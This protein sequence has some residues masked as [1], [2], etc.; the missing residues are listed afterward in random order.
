[1]AATNDGS[2][3]DTINGASFSVQSRAADIVIMTLKREV[4][5]YI[6]REERYAPKTQEGR[7]KLLRSFK[8]SIE[9]DSS[10][11]LTH[12]G[13]GVVKLIDEKYDG[14][15]LTNELN[16]EE[17]INKWLL[18]GLIKEL[19]PKLKEK[20]RGLELPIKIK[21]AV[22]DISS[23]RPYTG[24]QPQPFNILKSDNL[25]DTMVPIHNFYTINSVCDMTVTYE[26]FNRS[27]SHIV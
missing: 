14:V 24:R 8:L 20:Y 10:P 25:D 19:V 26:F 27:I 3:D 17:G 9:G 21:S 12:D 22:I 4:Y 23:I 11:S 13:Y 18:L 2:I 1:M 16:S 6:P 15:I 5:Y 7:D